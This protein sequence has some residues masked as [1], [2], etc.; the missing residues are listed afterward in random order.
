MPQIRPTPLRGNVL[1]SA[2]L[3]KVMAKGPLYDHLLLSASDI[4]HFYDDF[5]VDTIN[6]DQYVLVAGATATAFAHL[7]AENGIVRGVSGTT[8]ATSGLQLY[9]PA[10]WYGDRNAGCEVRFRTSVITETRW[11]FGFADALPAVDT[12]IG[13]NLSTPTFNTAADVAIYL[14]DDAS[15]VVTSGLYTDGTAITAAKTATTTNRPVANTYQT[16]RIQVLTNAVLLWVDGILLAQHAADSI[17]GGTALRFVISHKKS[18]TT[19]SNTD[20]D[21][22]RIWQERN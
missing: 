18:D 17:E 9:T 5:L 14:F 6:L 4:V 7:A 19:N 13:N 8:A 15:S 22:I 3:R 12:A 20:I 16:V 10:M 1:S 11:E 2:S 21:Y